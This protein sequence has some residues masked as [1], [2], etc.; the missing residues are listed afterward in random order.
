MRHL[1]NLLSAAR[2]ACFPVLLLLAGQGREQ[3]FTWLLLAALLSDILDGQIA[4]RCGF[5]SSRGAMLDSIA[6]ALTTGATAFGLWR[7]RP[8][9][10]Q[11]Y[12]HFVLL[13]LGLW[14]LEMA[15]SFWRYGQLSSFHTYAIRA[16]AYA[17]GIFVMVLLIWG[18]N[19]WLFAAAVAINVAGYLEEF[20][21]LWL[22]PQWT[23]DVRGAWWVLRARRG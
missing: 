21:L 19:S 7:L 18:F 3:A 22:L 2:I 20:L 23:A 6:D 15:A 12:G 17:L 16:G 8:D 11:E 14:V 10:V 13:V 4:R 9:F 5:T 1:P